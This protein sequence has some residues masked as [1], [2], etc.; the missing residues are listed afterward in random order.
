[1]F[2]L[3]SKFRLIMMLVFLLHTTKEYYIDDMYYYY[4]VIHFLKKYINLNRGKTMEYEII[5]FSKDKW[6][7]TENFVVSK[8]QVDENT[9][10]VELI[11]SWIK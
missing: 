2:C 8:E 9:D 3:I 7:G 11:M 5:H 6:K 10:E 4:H 1:M